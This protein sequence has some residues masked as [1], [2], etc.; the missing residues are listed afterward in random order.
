MNNDKKLT[1]QEHRETEKDKDENKE[2]APPL[3]SN[4][5]VPKPIDNGDEVTN[6]K[7]FVSGTVADELFNDENEEHDSLAGDDYA[8]QQKLQ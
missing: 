8:D 7:Q 2:A 3:D 4:H 5:K 1:S 6:K